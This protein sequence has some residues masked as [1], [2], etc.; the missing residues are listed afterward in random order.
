MTPGARRRSQTTAAADK[1]VV[2]KS[3]GGTDGKIK[4]YCTRARKKRTI[5][6][7]ERN[8]YKGEER[9][10]IRMM[11]RNGVKGEVEG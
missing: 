4:G 1:V 7:M 6:M 10:T 11:E 3:E 9:G 2:G 5:G 8:G